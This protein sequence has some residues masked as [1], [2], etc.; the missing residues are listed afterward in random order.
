MIDTDAIRKRWA[1]LG[2]QGTNTSIGRDLMGALDEVAR[3]RADLAHAEDKAQAAR[4]D[5]HDLAHELTRLT[6]VS[7]V[8]RSEIARLS[9]IVAC[10][11]EVH[12]AWNAWGRTHTRPDPVA[13]AMLRLRQ[14]LDQ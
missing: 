1:W 5:A 8:M 9:F 14:A 12:A 7:D 4:E 3:L 11:A 2:P 10:A 6:V 13:I